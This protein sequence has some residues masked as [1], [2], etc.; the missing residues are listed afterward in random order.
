MF[1]GSV[2]SKVASFAVGCLRIAKASKNIFKKERV[3]WRQN[4]IYFI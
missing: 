3:V 4:D 1:L 2:N